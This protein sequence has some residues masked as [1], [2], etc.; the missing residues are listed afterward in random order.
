MESGSLALE[1]PHGEV[2]P[3][4]EQM[5][6]TREQRLGDHQEDRSTPKRSGVMAMT[7]SGSGLGLSV[8]AV[9]P[10]GHG[11]VQDAVVEDVSLR[12]PERGEALV[13]RSEA[14]VLPSHASVHRNPG[15]SDAEQ[16]VPLDAT[17]EDH[18]LEITKL[19]SLVE[20]LSDRLD[21]CE[22]AQSFG[23]ASR[24]R[25]KS[26]D[27]EHAPAP[28]D[29]MTRPLRVPPLPIVQTPPAFRQF[30][31][32]EPPVLPQFG[33]QP[34]SGAILAGSRSSLGGYSPASCGPCGMFADHASFLNPAP[35]L[36]KHN[37]G[38]SAEG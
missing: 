25:I 8:P 4:G 31:F 2:Q 6:T 24:G 18:I 22:E 30:S 11:V 37:V 10:T 32:D 35:I 3:D 15:R 17:P 20:H 13:Q 36:E 29:L 26:S 14:S 16:I 21:K 1:A 28:E 7:A 27:L 9:D 33:L 38:V 12:T 23:S 19:R 34:F 5:K